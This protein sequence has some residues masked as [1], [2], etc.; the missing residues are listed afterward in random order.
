[1][2]FL[3]FVDA[4]KWKLNKVVET[5]LKDGK[6]GKFQQDIQPKGRP[7]SFWCPKFYLR[8]K[9]QWRTDKDFLLISSPNGAARENSLVV[10]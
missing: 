9:I 8:H 5:Y 3:L 7:K 2:I 10:K 6:F 1:M 4:W